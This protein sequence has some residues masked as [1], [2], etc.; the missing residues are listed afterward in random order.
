[1]EMPIEGVED[2]EPAIALAC[3]HVRDG[4]N[5]WSDPKMTDPNFLFG[6][7][8]SRWSGLR[9]ELHGCSPKP[10]AVDRNGAPT[11]RP[12]RQA[13]YPDLKKATP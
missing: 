12:M 5:G 3:K 4:V 7:F 2:I 9:E 11:V 1:V 13:I 8:V 10:K 6:S